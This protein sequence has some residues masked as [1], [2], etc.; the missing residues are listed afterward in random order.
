MLRREIMLDLLR[1]IIAVLLLVAGALT[2]VALVW[3]V[4][5]VLGVSSI[6][7]N[8]QQLFQVSLWATVLSALVCSYGLAGWS[9][10]RLRR[11]KTAFVASAICLLGFP[12]GTVLGLIALALVFI[13]AIHRRFV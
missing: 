8:R 5:Q 2:A 3:F 12:V 7:E 1:K 4:V 9:L 11:W 6:M 10:L 13:P